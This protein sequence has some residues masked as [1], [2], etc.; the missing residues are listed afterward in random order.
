MSSNKIG[1]RALLSRMARTTKYVPLHDG[2]VI[3]GTDSPCAPLYTNPPGLNVWKEM[4][5]LA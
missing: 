2:H 4:H 3:F 5:N 1:A